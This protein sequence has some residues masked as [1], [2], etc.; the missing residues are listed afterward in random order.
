MIKVLVSGAVRYAAYDHVIVVFQK[1]FQIFCGQV[2]S[3]PFNVLGNPLDPIVD[4]FFL[5]RLGGL[6]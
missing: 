5:E 6:F 3:L 4:V 1:G 2:L